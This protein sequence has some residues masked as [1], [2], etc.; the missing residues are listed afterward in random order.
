MASNAGDLVQFGPIGNRIC[1]IGRNLCQNKITPVLQNQFLRHFRR[2][3]RVG[4]AVLVDDLDGNRHTG[5][6]DPGNRIGQ[7]IQHEILGLAKAGQWPGLRA[8]DANLERRALRIPRGRPQCG[9][10]GQNDAA[11]FDE[12]TADKAGIDGCGILPNAKSFYL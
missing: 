12:L 7:P 3:V 5:I 10:G 9:G 11:L 2:Q 6:G 8:D 1:H 4:L